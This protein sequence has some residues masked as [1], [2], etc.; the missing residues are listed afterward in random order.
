MR[1]STI[2]APVFLFAAANAMATPE[3]EA[4]LEER[5][6]SNYCR[7]KFGNGSCTKNDWCKGISVSSKHHSCGWNKDVSNLFSGI[8]LNG[9]KG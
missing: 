6:M 9:I 5:R 1:F 7:T 4:G 3:A 2:I 8:E